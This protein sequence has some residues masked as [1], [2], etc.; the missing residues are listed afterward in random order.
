[1]AD[2]LKSIRDEVLGWLDEVGNTST[3]ADNVDAA[4]N[5]AHIARCTAQRW[6]FLKWPRWETFTTVAGQRVYSLHQACFSLELVKWSNTG[7]ILIEK[8]TR[9]VEQDTLPESSNQTPESY[10]FLGESAVQGQPSTPSLLSVVSS[11]AGDTGTVYNVVVTG[12]TSSGVAIS[13]TITPNGATPVASTNTFDV[14]ESVTATG[15]WTGTLTVTAG[16]VTI[17]TIGAGRG[18][19]FSPRLELNAPADAAHDFVYSFY[20]APRVLT[21][22]NEAVMIP[23]PF[24]KILVWDTLISFGGYNTDISN[25]ALSLW[26]SFAKKL[27]LQMEQH[28]LAGQTI[29]A[30]PRYVRNVERSLDAGIRI[31]R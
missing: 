25:Q 27:E 15:T 20:R 3:T 6:P 2:T 21:L 22:D 30:E 4:I 18:A 26:A 23:P 16:S 28:Y 11:N 14:V 8:T 13:E 17:V 19:T 1:M 12:W 10:R 5:Q 29:G 31:R 9:G 24:S 7:D